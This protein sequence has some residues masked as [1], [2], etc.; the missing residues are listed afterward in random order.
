[1]AITERDRLNLLDGADWLQFTKTWFI[2][3]PNPRTD[4]I[5][6]PATFP[7]SL[8]EAFIEFFTKPGD[9]LIDPFL[10]SGSTLKAAKKAG[11]NGVGIELYPLFSNFAEKSLLQI[12]GSAEC[13]VI[14]GNS[15]TELRKLRSSGI[16]F[17]F[18]LCSP[19][20]WSQLHSNSERHR[21]RKNRGLRTMYGDDPRD[22]GNIS[23]YERFL[24]QQ[25]LI[26]DE[27]YPLM[28]PKSYLVLITNN[29]YRNGRLYPLAFDTLRLLGEKWVPKDEKI[30]CQDYRKLRPF[31]MFHSYI[32]NRSHHYCLIFR[33]E[34]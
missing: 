11:R 24:S 10:G 29:V 32:G 14:Q 9:W 2:H 20:Y 23:D 3:N 28:K 31:G 30:W 13:R 33:K 22:L 25:K 12:E 1:L 8:A 27:L 21:D 34:L 15:R 4:K 19:P 5:L 16:E 26:F 7:E 18:C 6:H 17:S